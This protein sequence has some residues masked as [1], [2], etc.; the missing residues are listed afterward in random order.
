L[1]GRAGAGIGAGV[2]GDGRRNS[3]LGQ[4]VVEVQVGVGVMATKLA[5]VGF[6]RAAVS[7]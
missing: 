5:G 3:E 1:G 7:S 6:S 2:A 4:V